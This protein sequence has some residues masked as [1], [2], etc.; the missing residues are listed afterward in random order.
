MT[1]VIVFFLLIW[2]FIQVP[3][4]LWSTKHSHNYTGGRHTVEIPHISH[5]LDWF[6]LA[7]GGAILTFFGIT[8]TGNLGPGLLFIWNIYCFWEGIKSLKEYVKDKKEDK[9]HV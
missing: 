4:F 1:E 8:E 5:P 7:I 6:C 2:C 3:L 9:S